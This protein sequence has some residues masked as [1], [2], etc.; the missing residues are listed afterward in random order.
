MNL[1]LLLE[2][3]GLIRGESTS[4]DDYENI[5]PFDPEKR[6][7]EKD[8]VIIDM[9]NSQGHDKVSFCI[10]DPH[11]PDNP[12]IYISEGFSKLT[13]YAFEEVVGRNCRFL[14]GLE[15]AK[16]DIKRISEAIKGEKDVSVNLMNHKKDGTKFINEF[17][18]ANLR[19]PNKELAYYIGVQLAVDS[20][21][22]GQMPS[23]PGWVYSNGNHV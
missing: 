8:Y 12:V 23:N 22:G 9:L 1:S 6:L 7:C 16:E 5:R 19:T 13:G 21:D 20:R 15:T 17:F 18:L 2:W 14:Q 11:Q 3:L 4:D 10:T